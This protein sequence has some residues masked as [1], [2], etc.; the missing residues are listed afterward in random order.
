ML[1]LIILHLLLAGV[2]MDSPGF[3][4]ARRLRVSESCNSGGTKWSNELQNKQANK[5]Q[6]RSRMQMPT[7]SRRMRKAGKKPSEGRAKLLR[8]HEL[9]A[10]TA[11]SPK[12]TGLSNRAPAI[13]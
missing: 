1:V 10:R 5:H 13:R 9:E 3:Q 6:A 2:H 8:K 12:A 7:K 4:R 11:I